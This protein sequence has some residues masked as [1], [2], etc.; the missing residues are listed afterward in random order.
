MTAAPEGDRDNSLMEVTFSQLLITLIGTGAT[1]LVVYF[2]FVTKTSERLSVL[3][4]HHDIFWKVLEPHLAGIIHSPEHTDRD[5]LVD[6]LVHDAISDDELLELNDL[7]SEATTQIPQNDK[8]LAAALLLA[9]TKIVIT[10]RKILWG[11]KG[12]GKY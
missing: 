4:A 10:Q 1:L 6:K 12:N 2:G 3:E 5:L 9:R 8:C 11:K 7:L